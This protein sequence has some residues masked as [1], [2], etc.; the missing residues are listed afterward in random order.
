MSE[1]RFYVTVQIQTDDQ[2][3]DAYG[4]WEIPSHL[5]DE[6]HLPGPTR[7]YDLFFSTN[8]VFN[9]LISFAISIVASTLKLHGF[10]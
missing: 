9:L 3:P 1:D 2:D 8:D 5:S 10:M 4:S 7:R 6:P